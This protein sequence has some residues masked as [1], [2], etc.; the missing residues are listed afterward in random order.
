[1]TADA[2]YQ[3]VRI[4]ELIA[5][6]LTRT[7]TLVSSKKIVSQ[8]EL[9]I[10]VE[11][12]FFKEIVENIRILTLHDN[13]NGEGGGGGGEGRGRRKKRKLP[14]KIAILKKI[15][16]SQK[17]LSKKYLLGLSMSLEYLCADLIDSCCF[18]AFSRKSKIINSRDIYISIEQDVEMRTFF[19]KENIFIVGC[20]NLPIVLKDDDAESTENTYVIAKHT[21]NRLIRTI[22]ADRTSED[23]EPAS[24]K[25]S[26]EFLD[27]FQQYTEQWVIK[28]LQKSDELCQLNNRKIITPEDLAWVYKNCC[29]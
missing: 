17:R 11:L 25:L 7:S 13:D 20:G 8:K 6:I 3:M 21:F 15:V 27:I 4:F 16:F 9:M 5:Q 12:L 26:K 14:M 29:L 10:S 2:T 19:A 28:L 18:Q 23:D 22:L 24:T 1:M